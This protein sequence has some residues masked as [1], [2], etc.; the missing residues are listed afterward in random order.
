MGTIQLNS[1]KLSMS[2]KMPRLRLT[3]N[4]TKRDRSRK[5]S[6]RDAWRIGAIKLRLTKILIFIS[7]WRLWRNRK[8]KTLLN[9]VKLE[10]K[11]HKWLM[12]QMGLSFL[13]KRLFCQDLTQ[14]SLMVPILYMQR[15][16]QLY[17]RRQKRK[18]LIWLKSMQRSWKM[19]RHRMMPSSMNWHK[20]LNKHSKMPRQL[21]EQPL[22]QSK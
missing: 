17:R 16:W 10:I 4:L 1:R 18:Q 13:L 22:W 7:R 6:W 15:S 3:E 5:M 12:Q 9:P 14:I 2:T 11:S 21:R 8:K 20:R 19:L